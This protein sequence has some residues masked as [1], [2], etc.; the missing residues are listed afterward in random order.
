MVG[1]Q[2]H[3][4]LLRPSVAGRVVLVGDA[5]RLAPVPAAKRVEL[6]V[7]GDAGRLSSGSGKGAPFFQGDVGICASAVV[8]N[9]TLA[10]S[11]ASRAVPRCNT[12]DMEVSSS[13]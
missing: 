6:A 10:I 8:T 4:A 1:R 11:T 13:S 2:R 5:A 9:A 7:E 12:F 3:R